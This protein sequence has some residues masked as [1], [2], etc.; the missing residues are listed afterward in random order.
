MMQARTGAGRRARVR[1]EVWRWWEG[2][3]ARVSD[4]LMVK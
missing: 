4:G 2:S 3:G 1:V